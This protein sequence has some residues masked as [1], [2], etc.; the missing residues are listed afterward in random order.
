[1]HSVPHPIGH[2][3]VTIVLQVGCGGNQCHYRLI[4]RIDKL[5]V[6]MMFDSEIK[7]ER[8]DTEKSKNSC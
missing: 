8:L 1:M 7:G 3:E 4:C 2:V 6:L 5:G